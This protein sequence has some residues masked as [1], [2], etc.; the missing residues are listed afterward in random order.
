M[1]K[2]FTILATF[3]MLCAVGCEEQGGDDV[4]PNDKPNT[5]EPSDKPNDGGGNENENPD[6]GEKPNDGDENDKPN[7][8]EQYKI[9]VYNLFGWES[10]YIYVWDKKNLTEYA[11]KWCGTEMTA[12]EEINGHTYLVYELPEEAH[13]REIGVIFNNGQ[14]TQTPDW[15][16]TLDKD[17]YMLL[18][19]TYPTIIQ[20]KNNPTEN[21]YFDLD[22]I[23]DTH[24]IYYTSTDGNIVI[25]LARNISGGNLIYNYMIGDP[26]E[27]KGVMVFDGAVTSFGDA[28]FSKLSSN[29]ESITI[30]NSVTSIGYQAFTSCSNLVSVNIPDS[31]ISIGDYAFQF[32]SSLDNIHIPDSV[33]SIGCAAFSY[34]NSLTSVTI[35]DSIT[36]LADYV[37][38]ACSSLTSVT[39]PSSITSIGY[40]AFEGCSSL[41]RVTIPKSV[42]SIGF[43]AFSGCTG[44]LFVNCNIPNSAF[45][46]SAFTKATI[47]EGVTSIGDTAFQFC[48][49]L[50]SI[51]IPDSVNKIGH[52]AFDGCLSLVSINIPESI[53][54]IGIG[55][56]AGCTSLAS[57]R[58]PNSVTSIGEGAFSGCLSLASITIPEGVTSIGE[59]AFQYCSSLERVYCKPVTPPYAHYSCSHS[60]SGCYDCDDRWDAFGWFPDPD[61]F[62][63]YVPSGS[64]DKYKTARGWRHYKEYI[65]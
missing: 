15:F 19:G 41:A 27:R 7:T 39:I 47:G 13:D 29:L 4:N 56:F 52:A 28:V 44:E 59:E 61:G 49:S 14:G 31:V 60:S 1:K 5:E 35:P 16:V 34:C 21:Y 48:E 32:C 45:Y 9:Y 22:R 11:G 36:S 30:P 50:A 55:V 51:T 12:T 3:A 37:F 24:K 57:I 10:V 64:E 23:P 40:Q 46:K 6:D 18:W 58:I 33:N 62:T 42:I 38:D 8:Q 25:P 26:A 54:S 65:K 17:C 20:D 43:E 53:T 2:L 63:I